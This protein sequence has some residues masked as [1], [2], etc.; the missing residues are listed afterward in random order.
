[1][2][3]LRNF[4]LSFEK[5]GSK[6]KKILCSLS[7]LEDTLLRMAIKREKHSSLKEFFKV[8]IRNVIVQCYKLLTIFTVFI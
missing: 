7:S 4:I 1:M 8:L 2:T 5:T 3:A 6:V